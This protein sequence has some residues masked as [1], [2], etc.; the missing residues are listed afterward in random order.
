[1]RIF[2]VSDTHDIPEEELRLIPKEA[3]RQ[4]CSC[5][6]HC[7]D[8]E[9]RHIGHEA[10]GDL[11]IWV[12]L[13]NRNNI[14]LYRHGDETFFAPDNGDGEEKPEEN[15]E[16]KRL[17]SNWHILP[18]RNDQ[19]IEFGKT[20]K[21]RIY[22]YHYLG[23]DILRDLNMKIPTPA[24]T[25]KDMTADEKTQKDPSLALKYKLTFFKR[26]VKRKTW[27]KI[28]TFELVE[29]VRSK[30]GEIHY[31]LFGHSHHQF[32][33]VNH[34]MALVNPGAFCEDFL[35]RPKRSY[36]VID[37]KTWEITFSKVI[38]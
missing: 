30:F 15:K 12:I 31:V 2:V 21:I 22:I 38:L 29:E 5:I 28:K 23:L 19:I 9:D 3:I 34:D 32:F 13:S 6:I 20:K 25:V 37:T 17:L 7:G 10:L 33:H 26:F 11:P 1:M 24:G 16:L 4:N 18:D 8:M 27:P 36:A 35:G 14:K